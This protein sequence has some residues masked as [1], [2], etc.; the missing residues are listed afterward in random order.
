MAFLATAALGAVWSSCGQD[1]ATAGAAARLRQLEPKVLFSSDGYQLGGQWIDK[2]VGHP[3]LLDTAARVEPQLILLDSD[4]YREVVATPAEPEVTP[5]RFRS[6]PVGAVHLRH[7]RTAQGDRARPRRR[8][9]RAPESPQSCTADMGPGDVFF[10]Q[11]AL[12]WMMWNLRTSGLL[13]GAGV[14]SYSGHPLYP[15]ADRLWEV[16]EDQRVSYFGTSPGH[17]LACRKAGLHPGRDHDLS[18]LHTLGSTGSPLPV[19]SFEWVKAEVG[20]QVSRC[21]RSAAAPTW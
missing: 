14:V 12:S 15:D 5:V 16:V 8:D 2:T 4:A 19:E 1:Y 17:L 7:H 3:E 11:T 6:S 9:A 18:R 13:F 20:R 21:P 10:W